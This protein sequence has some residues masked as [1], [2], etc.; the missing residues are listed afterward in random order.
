MPVT[1][2]GLEACWSAIYHP[3]WDTDPERYLTSG[4]LK[5]GGNR[6]LARFDDHLHAL[7]AY[8]GV[9]HSDPSHWGASGPARTRYFL[10]FFVS[11]KTISLH[12]YDTLGEAQAALST[13]H[14][15]LV[16]ESL[17]AES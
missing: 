13:F 8:I 7:K 3:E 15:Q 4:L 14:R 16:D 9:H 2:V 6:R 1:D 5:R 11:G 10:S 17:R 12:T